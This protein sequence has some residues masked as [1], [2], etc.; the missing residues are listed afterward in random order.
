MYPPVDPTII[1]FGPFALRWYG[2]LM[3]TAVIFRSWFTTK[4][5]ERRVKNPDDFWDM[6]IWV[7]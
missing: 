7:I 6:L 2:L 3:A 4:E 1:E 5:I